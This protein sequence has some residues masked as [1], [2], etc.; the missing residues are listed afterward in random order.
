MATV[1]H[2]NKQ[3]SC[4][5]IALRGRAMSGQRARWIDEAT[6]REMLD[7]TLEAIRKALSSGT[8]EYHIGSRGLKRY[9][10]ID[11]YKML[12]YWREQVDDILAGGTSIKSR[13]VIP[14][15]S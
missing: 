9:P 8:L 11:L 13:R 3:A 1:S 7:L 2:Y 12:D 6:A 5:E 10:L 4:A 14:N 15:D